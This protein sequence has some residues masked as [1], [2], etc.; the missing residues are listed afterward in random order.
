MFR[1]CS[2]DSS[3]LCRGVTPRR[4]TRGPYGLS[5]LPPSCGRGSPQACCEASSLTTPRVGCPPEGV[6]R[7]VFVNR[8]CQQAIGGNAATAALVKLFGAVKDINRGT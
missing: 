7:K 8:E 5:L 3:V 1:L 2:N 6:P 4:R